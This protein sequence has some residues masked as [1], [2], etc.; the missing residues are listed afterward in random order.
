MNALLLAA[1][2]AASP[3]I[4]RLPVVAEPRPARPWQQSVSLHC[5]GATYRIA[6]YGAAYPAHTTVTITV[7]R[8]P[9]RGQA[10]ALLARDLAERGA[11][12]RIA[13]LCGRG[14]SDLQL[15]IYRGLPRPGQPVAFHVGA[16]W[17]SRGGDVTYSGLEQSDA[18]TFWF[19]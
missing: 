2:L 17:L 18:E 5:N 11:A 12:Y 15:L 4:A 7:N 14:N 10:A 13:G 1:L 8:R 16:A 9:V 3:P 19:R 6:G